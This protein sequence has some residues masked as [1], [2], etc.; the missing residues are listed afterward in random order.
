MSNM[1]PVTQGY[2]RLSKTGGLH[3]EPENGRSTS[4]R[5]SK[6]GERTSSTPQMRGS[7][8]S[9]PSGTSWWVGCG[10][11]TPRRGLAGPVQP[12]LRRGGEKPGGSHQAEHRRRGYQGGH[13]HR[14]R[15]RRSQAS[16]QDDAGPVSPLNENTGDIC[17]CRVAGI[18]SRDWQKYFNRVDTR[19]RGT[20]IASSPEVPL[21]M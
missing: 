3:T 7:R 2:A 5:S 17:I 16:P 20:A 6:S 18:A 10:P 9:R 8:M 1:V 21:R 14:R 4:F 13:T 15:Q 11:M 12:E 19:H